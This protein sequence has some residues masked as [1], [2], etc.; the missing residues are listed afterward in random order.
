MTVKTALDKGWTPGSQRTVQNQAPCSK[1]WAFPAAILQG[2]RADRSL[3]N[4]A[5][6]T[7]RK[8]SWHGLPP[9]GTVVDN[10]RHD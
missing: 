9:P 10:L 1:Q 3:G 7:A 4:S 6:S 5:F 2:D 8:K